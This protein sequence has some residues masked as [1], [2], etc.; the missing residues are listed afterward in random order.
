MFGRR[1]RL[2]QIIFG[3]R[4]KCRFAI[5]IAA[6]LSGNLEYH[7]RRVVTQYLCNFQKRRKE[8]QSSVSSKIKKLSS[9]I[10]TQKFYRQALK[11]LFSFFIITIS[12]RK[13]WK[14]CAPISLPHSENHLLP[15]LRHDPQPLLLHPCLNPH[16]LS[17][18]Q[19]YLEQLCVNFR[20]S[21][22]RKSNEW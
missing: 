1:H 20:I 7:A 22:F 4:Q 10:G 2:V 14:Y 15:F 13:G 3:R 8:R 21:I 12:R 9:S 5:L 19:E 6:Y 11:L 18:E 16:W 17:Y